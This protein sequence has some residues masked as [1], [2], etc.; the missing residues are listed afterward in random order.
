[1]RLEEVGV[2]NS[3]LKDG[4]TVDYSLITV[5]LPNAS[6]SKRRPLPNACSLGEVFLNACDFRRLQSPKLHFRAFGRG[7]RLGEACVWNKSA[8]LNAEVS[9]KAVRLEEPCVWERWLS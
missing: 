9:Q 7:R 5:P 4:K 3:S 1:M 6:S 2:W 8:V